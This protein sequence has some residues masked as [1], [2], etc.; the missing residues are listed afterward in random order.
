MW[1]LMPAAS[2][3]ALPLAYR[4]S[5]RLVKLAKHCANSIKRQLIDAKSVVHAG[6]RLTNSCKRASEQWR[7][8]GREPEQVQAS[9][10]LM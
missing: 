8:Q 6:A 3:P 5:G 7:R 1:R 10:T 9:P 4:Q 2:R